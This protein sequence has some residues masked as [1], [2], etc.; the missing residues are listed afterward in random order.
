MLCLSKLRRHPRHLHSF[1]GLSVA[2]FDQLLAEFRPAYETQRC[3]RQTDSVRRRQP[4]MLLPGWAIKAV[5]SDTLKTYLMF[6]PPPPPNN[7]SK[8]VPVGAIDWGWSGTAT[9]QSGKW[10]VTS[11]SKSG[12]TYSPASD[13]PVWSQNNASGTVN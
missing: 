7:D 12:P 6:L 4:G 13:H 2:Q 3:Q 1:T 8:W 9:K 5:A 11:K 10:S